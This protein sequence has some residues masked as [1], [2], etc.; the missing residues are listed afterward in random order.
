LRLARQLILFPLA[1]AL[2]AAGVFAAWRLVWVPRRAMQLVGLE[3][4]WMWSGRECLLP[5]DQSWFACSRVTYDRVTALS[6]HGVISG[7]RYTGALNVAAHQW[8]VPDSLHWR[9]AQDSV[10]QAMRARGG[11]PI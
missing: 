8:S 4:P 3:G 11:R 1:A 6:E 5:H 2:C 10:R 7:N 9:A